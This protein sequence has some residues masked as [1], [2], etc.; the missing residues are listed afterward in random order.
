M[1][2]LEPYQNRKLHENTASPPLKINAD[3]ANPAG[4]QDGQAVYGHYPRANGEYMP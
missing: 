2:Y 4:I 3:G 1:T